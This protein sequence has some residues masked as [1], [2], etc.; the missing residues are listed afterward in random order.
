ELAD[1][2]QPLLVRVL[3]LVLE[4]AD[5]LDDEN[6]LATAVGDGKAGG[7]G[8]DVDLAAVGGDVPVDI[9][10]RL[11]VA[12]D[13]VERAGDERRRAGGVEAVREVAGSADHGVDRGGELT[14]EGSIGEH[15]ALVL[16]D[17]TQAVRDGI[18]D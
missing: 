16:V 12:G 3:D 1:L 5:R 10:D 2:G 9:A 11:V 13:G 17:D 4:V 15:H 6:S 7:G 8:L 14:G 18:D